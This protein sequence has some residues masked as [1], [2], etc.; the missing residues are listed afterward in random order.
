VGRV[1]SPRTVVLI[2]HVHGAAR[3]VAPTA[4]AFPHRDAP[5]GLVILSAW[6]DP[7]DDGR[8]V[9]WTRELAAA[10]RP[11]ATGGAYVNEA[12]DEKPAAA[13]GV[14]HERLVAIKNRYDPTNLFRHNTNIAPTA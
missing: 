5:H 13:F 14:N 4:T 6:D 12:W 8:N 7:A 3:R 1:P 2:D 9:R 11:F 10:T